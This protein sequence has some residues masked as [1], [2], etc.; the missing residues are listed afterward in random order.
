[1]QC[2]MSDCSAEC[3]KATLG[4]D[5]NPTVRMDGGCSRCQ[6]FGYRSSGA[7]S[8]RL[9][10]GPDNMGADST[11]IHA[12]VFGPEEPITPDRALFPVSPRMCL[13]GPPGIGPQ[14]AFKRSG[15][16]VP[17]DSHFQS[18]LEL[19][20]TCDVPA[21]W[22]CRAGVCH[23]SACAFIGGAVDFHPALPRAACRR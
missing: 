20:E 19:A 12:E 13:S 15:L 17:W 23:S 7:C 11:R 3:R 2:R 10:R 14:I 6:P 4:E 21:R 16:T 1:M 9:Y 8:A 5:R 22:S 18:L